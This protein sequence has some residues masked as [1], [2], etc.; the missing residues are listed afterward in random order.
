MNIAI[1]ID[2]KGFSKEL[3]LQEFLPFIKVTK[4]P[5]ISFYSEELL[6]TSTVI[7]DEIT[8][9]PKGKIIKSSE[10]DVNILQYYEK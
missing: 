2:K 6:T 3:R 4:A 8:F 9:Y 5:L 1:L 10:V 7:A